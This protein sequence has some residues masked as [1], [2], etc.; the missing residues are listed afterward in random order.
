MT[1]GVA[2]QL[3]CIRVAQAKTLHGRAPNDPASS[4]C[5]WSIL[6][7]ELAFSSQPGARMQGIEPPDCPRSP[8]RPLPLSAV[9]D[10]REH[11]DLFDSNEVN[12]R[13]YGINTYCLQRVQIWGEVVA[14]MEG[15]RTGRNSSSSLSSHNQL[16]LKMYEA[17][18]KLSYHHLIRKVKFQHR[19]PSELSG[20]REYWTPW[21]LMQ[22]SYH[23]SQAALNNPFLHLVALRGSR[24]VSQA[25][26][27][28][29]ETLDRALFHASWVTRFLQICEELRFDTSDPLLGQIVAATATIPWLFQFVSDDAISSRARQDFQTC[30]RALGRISTHWPHIAQMVCT[31]LS[32]CYLI[33]KQAN[34]AA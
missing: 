17:E 5:Y 8:A 30:E 15:I 1:I 6:I 23:G 4:W 22:I 21:T 12:G 31:W 3:H 20:N 14:F 29:Q 10:T 16:T 13:D 7:L 28:L 9:T 34:R 26:S 11:P 25:R 33:D 18:S 32:F 24:G 27:F 2:S 19:Q